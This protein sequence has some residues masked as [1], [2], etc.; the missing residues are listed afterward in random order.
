M[1]ALQKDTKQIADFAVGT[2][3]IKTL[4]KVIDTILLSE[5]EKFIQ[6]SCIYT[7]I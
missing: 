1:Y 6:T 3:T 5:P 4:K 2:R 7:I